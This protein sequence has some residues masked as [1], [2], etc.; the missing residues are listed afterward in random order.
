MAGSIQQGTRAPRFHSGKPNQVIRVAEI[1]TL[2]VVFTNSEGREAMCQVQ[3]FGKDVDDG[4]PG[5]Y[6]LAEEQQMTEALKLASPTVKN[7]VRKWLASQKDVAGESIPAAV[8]GQVA[9]P[10]TDGGFD[11]GKVEVGGSAE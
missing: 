6:V 8:L 11:I 5:V 1:R 9:G 2:A 3:V 7:G 10:V 4:G